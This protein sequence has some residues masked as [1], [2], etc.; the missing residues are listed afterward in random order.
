[1]NY[2]KILRFR[3]AWSGWSFYRRLCG[4]YG[5]VHRGLTSDPVQWF[6]LVVCVVVVQL[7]CESE[8]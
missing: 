7:S 3:G 5:A 4:E 1:M 2:Q 8:R 6:D